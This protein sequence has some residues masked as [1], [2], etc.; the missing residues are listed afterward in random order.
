MFIY[1]LVLITAIFVFLGNSIPVYSAAK[2][3]PS[4]AQRKVTWSDAPPIARRMAFTLTEA[5]SL[6]NDKESPNVN[7]CPNPKV[8]LTVGMKTGKPHVRGRWSLTP[9]TYNIDR[10]Y[11]NEPGN[12]SNPALFN[13]S[14]IYRYSPPSSKKR[15]SGVPLTR[16]DFAV[17]THVGT[18]FARPDQ[19]AKMKSNDEKGYAR[20]LNKKH[21][22]Y[23]YEYIPDMGLNL[24]RNTMFCYLPKN[25]KHCQ[26]EIRLASPKN[27][28][29]VNITL[30][31]R[32]A[33]CSQKRAKE[34]AR[35][36]AI[37]MA[38]KLWGM[39]LKPPGLDAGTVGFVDVYPCSHIG[40]TPEQDRHENNVKLGSR[41]YIA[42]AYRTPATANPIRVDMIFR[43]GQDAI[44]NSVERTSRRKIAHASDTEDPLEK[45]LCGTDTEYGIGMIEEEPGKKPTGY[46]AKFKK[47]A[48][49]TT[50]GY[51]PI[52]TQEY[53]GFIKGPGAWKVDLELI[54]IISRKPEKLRRL[55]TTSTKIKILDNPS[56]ARECF[57]DPKKKQ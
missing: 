46:D 7:Y 53:D 25:G 11:R 13:V 22:T 12:R 34:I 29:T 50:I 54:E 26:V 44:A 23:G 14:S 2:D 20:N 48:N 37:V 43:P 45:P 19:I 55:S 39:N 4:L 51:V 33:A 28:A 16:I 40:A 41:I 3:R 21:P 5:K 47:M 24:H 1:R 30:I 35:G 31:M 9:K 17:T 52:Y 56:I 10:N 36:A 32:S 57:G 15:K 42:V 27:F 8:G 49:G 6:F 38:N 18:F